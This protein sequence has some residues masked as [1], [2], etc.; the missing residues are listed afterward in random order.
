MSTKDAKISEEFDKF[1]NADLWGDGFMDADPLRPVSW[2]SY[3]AAGLISVYHAAFLSCIKPYVPKNGFALEIGPGM[4]AWTKALLEAGAARVFA[5]D[6]QPASN[7]GIYKHL[8][9]LRAKLTYIVARDCSGQGVPDGV[10][11]FWSFGTFV[12]LSPEVQREYI[13]M[14]ARKVRPGAHGFIQFADFEQ[15]NR[16]VSTVDY[17]IHEWLGNIIGGLDG[18]SVRDICEAHP[19][20]AVR[21]SLSEKDLDLETVHP[22]RYFYVGTNWLHQTLSDAKLEVLDVNVIPSLRDPIIHF[23]RPA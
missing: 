5:I 4:G 12:H 9:D 3:G 7:E 8:G 13:A 23:R 17:R 20:I 11:F 1:R 6:V 19:A 14:I 18:K 2:S 22:G 21:T 16:V 15:W 10:D